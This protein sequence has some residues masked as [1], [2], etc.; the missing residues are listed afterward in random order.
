MTQTTPA[1]ET[2][3]RAHAEFDAWLAAQSDEVQQLTLLQ[4]IELYADPALLEAP[5]NPWKGMP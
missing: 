1:E 2:L 5:V 3:R 4:Q